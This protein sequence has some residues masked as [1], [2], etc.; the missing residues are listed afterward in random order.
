MTFNAHAFAI[1]TRRI[2]E[3]GETF[4]KATVAE[5][6]H[7][8]TYEDTPQEA[9]EVLIDDIEALHASSIGLNH[10]FPEPNEELAHSGRITLRLSKSLHQ[11]LDSQ[12]KAENV[13][14]NLHIV[15]LL[16]K[17]VTTADVVKQVGI[18]VRAVA[19]AAITTAALMRG[20]EANGIYPATTAYSNTSRLEIEREDQKWI[21]QH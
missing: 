5:L 9:Y 13:S 18:E 12:A 11:T 8:A 17:G 6:P 16:A 21:T 10:P 4:F 2:T 14:L 20:E 7:L 19:R 3:N 1:Q 15:T